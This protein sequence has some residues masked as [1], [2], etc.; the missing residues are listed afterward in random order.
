ML[1]HV[2]DGAGAADVGYLGLKTYVGT[3]GVAT[4]KWRSEARPK[5][6]PQF[7][8]VAKAPSEQ[9]P[10]DHSLNNLNYKRIVGQLI[11]TWLCDA[12]RKTNV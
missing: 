7:G 9:H 8:S 6:Q 4:Q 12:T 5:F 2:I 1:L 3:L 10:Y 11:C